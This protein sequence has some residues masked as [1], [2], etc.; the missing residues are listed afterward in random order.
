MKTKQ[1]RQVKVHG[2][3]RPAATTQGRHYNGGKYVPWLRVNG[4]WLERAGF[5]IGDRIGIDVTNN[6]LI[7]KKLSADGDHRN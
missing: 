1:T 7:I 4:L 6:R 2:L 3:Y 5:K